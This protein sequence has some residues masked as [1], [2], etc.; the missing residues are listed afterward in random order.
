[1]EQDNS[2]VVLG[3]D[4]AS[5]AVGGYNQWQT[6]GFQ[7]GKKRQKVRIK[8]H[9]LHSNLL[10]KHLSQGYNKKDKSCTSHIL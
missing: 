7:P 9:S 2:R 6:V 4:G 10:Q 3:V 5:V 8:I 1:M